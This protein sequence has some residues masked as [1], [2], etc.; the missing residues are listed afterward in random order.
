MTGARDLR[1]WPA[2]PATGLAA[3]SIVLASAVGEPGDSTRQSFAFGLV[4]VGVVLGLVGL[5][6]AY[7]AVARGSR[8][9]AAVVYAVAS[10]CAAAVVGSCCS[11]SVTRSAGRTTEGGV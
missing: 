3:T 1:G 8:A 11:S 4:F 5:P 9:G 6:L 7:S 10:V 2:L